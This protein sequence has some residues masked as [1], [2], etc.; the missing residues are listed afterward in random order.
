MWPSQ[1][2]S[3]H[4][5]LR[6]SRDVQMLIKLLFVFVACLLT[7]LWTKQIINQFHNLFRKRF[8]KNMD[9]VKCHSLGGTYCY[10][11]PQSP[12]FHFYCWN[13]SSDFHHY[14]VLLLHKFS[15]VSI[16][17]LFACQSI[18]YTTKA[19]VMLLS[20]LKINKWIKTFYN[21]S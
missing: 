17:V 11:L 12:N 3:Q 1:L 5:G 13:H 8:H 9:T 19:P 7:S 6:F 21:F 20:F 10:S 15:I 2:S 18:C 16:S 4:S 14:S